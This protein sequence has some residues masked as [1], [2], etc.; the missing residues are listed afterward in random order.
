VRL[1]IGALLVSALVALLAA[2]APMP[3]WL[4]PARPNWLGLWVIFWIL[5]LPQHVG[6]LSAW[7]IGLVFDGM[8]GSLLG[9]H[10][11]GLVVV[12]YFAIVL[13]TRML[14]Y[15]LAQQ[16]A[17]AAVLCG[18]GL[19]IAHWAQGLG[20]RSSMNLWFLMGGLTSAACW[21]I[22]SMR[23]SWVRHMEGWDAR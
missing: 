2:L 1:P 9:P 16:V 21:P 10:A 11:L 5:R 20:G 13:R 23:S 3:E 15:A 22:V 17:L 19:F 14:H 6:L 12:A 4:A 8:S 7:S 18:G